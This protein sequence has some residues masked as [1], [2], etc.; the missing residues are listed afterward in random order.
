VSDPPQR[1]ALPTPRLAEPDAPRFRTLTPS[2]TGDLD[3]RDTIALTVATFGLL[4][5]DVECVAA[6]GRP[7]GSLDVV[8]ASGPGGQRL[9]GRGFPAGPELR[10][11]LVE[12]E[13]PVA[14]S[15]RGTTA[16]L[17]RMLAFRVGGP[18]LEQHVAIGFLRPDGG[19]LT[20]QQR[21]VG[22]DFARMVAVAVHRGIHLASTS[23]T[24]RQ[25]RVVSEIALELTTSLEADEVLSCLVERAAGA[26]DADAATIWSI[27]PDGHRP[28][29][30]WERE[31]GPDPAPAADLVRDEELITVAL[32][33]RRTVVERRPPAAPRR[34]RMAGL[35]YAGAEP[36]A[37][38]V[39]ARRT[40]RPFSAIE[41]SFVD[42]VSDIGGLALRN[43]GHF[44][45]AHD[46]RRSA[47]D[48]ALRMLLAM[49]MALDLAAALPAHDAAARV[50]RHAAVTS[51]ADRATLY[52]VEGDEEVVAASW[53]R[54]GRERPAG[55][56]HP[57]RRHA[58]VAQA[59]RTGHP[60]RVRP[61]QDIPPALRYGA[62]IPLLMAGEERSFIALARGRD[63][64][65]TANDQAMMRLV[66][67]LG[68]LALRNAGLLAR[69]EGARDA[70]AEALRG[71]AVRNR[72]QGALAALRQ[73]LLGAGSAEQL[74][75]AAVRTVARALD[76]ELVRIT[77]VAADG[78]AVVRASHGWRGV[79]AIAPGDR[80]EVAVLLAGED[81]LVFADLGLE[82]RFEPSPALREHGVRSGIS[83]VVSGEERLFGELAAYSTLPGALG[84]DA[85]LF[86]RL[87]ASA[88]AAALMRRRGEEALERGLELLRRTDDARRTLLGRLI[89]SVEDEREMIARDIHDDALQVMA[90]TMLR[91]QLLEEG[92]DDE[93]W[94]R[95][96]RA[97][98]ET[99]DATVG[100]LRRLIFDL[101]A[102][103]LDQGLGTALHQYTAQLATGV[104]ATYRVVDRL[105]ATPAPQ[106]RLIVYRIV[107]EAL[108][109][110]R[111][112][113]RAASV[114]VVL[115]SEGDLVHVS[116][117]DDGRGF[118]VERADRSRSPGMAAMRERAELA[119]GRLSIVSAPGAGTRVDLWVPAA[120]I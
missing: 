41:A 27:Q 8:A 2:S 110:T 90:A 49:D 38:L 120:P 53:D 107:Q 36:M 4:L 15:G 9:V 75:D 92:D 31:P 34:H 83:V 20:R 1:T 23:W 88:V 58:L 86:L 18:V 116:V 28:A 68:G 89:R 17:R 60:V 59:L 39:L 47:D 7:D 3:V 115:E 33:E 113:A 6:I 73:A 85:L 43:A 65:F 79:P 21:Q 66:A 78:T 22:D 118:V 24:A 64:P 84:E 19:S 54:E 45:D 97:A 103:A 77:E 57:L 99:L 114:E 37:V 14:T 67:T 40:D 87:V 50:L 5:P 63:L 102:D 48:T 106:T 30:S 44:A 101:R 105:A 61:R 108:V 112:H 71:L 52:R 16:G 72:Q 74:L 46:A 98:L 109:N 95:R 51:R 11:R 100:R 96:V 69:A 62:I 93:A 117:R 56:R 10:Q 76:V 13:R 80:S 42:A 81:P 104:G 29:A 55:E 111:R 35:L 25:L 26:A 12:T 70:A 82:R 32:A 119:G 91:L 94:R